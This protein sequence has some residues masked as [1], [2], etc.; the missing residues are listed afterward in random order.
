ML[1]LEIENI[2]RLI[3]KI[4]YK[5]FYLKLI[6]TMEEDYTNWEDFD[7]TPRVAN[8]VDGGVIEL[9]PVNNDKLY[10]FKYVNAHSKNP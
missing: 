3:S 7:K 2:R 10:S 6:K 5:E 4:G 8:H 9:M 1:I